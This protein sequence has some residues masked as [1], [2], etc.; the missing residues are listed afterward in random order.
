[1]NKRRWPIMLASLL[2]AFLIAT[3]P[4]FSVENNF[5]NPP[6]KVNINSTDNSFKSLYGAVCLGIF[7]Y[8][9][10]AV[11]KLTK[12]EIVRQYPDILFNS[13]IRFDL[14]NLDLGKKGWTRYY[15]FSVGNKDFIMRIFL[16]S[17]RAFQAPVAALFEGNIEQP[18]VTFQVLPC[19]NEILADCKIK[20]TRIYP[21]RQ[22]DSSP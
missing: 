1:M 9:L 10:D 22:V 16:T 2:L 5:L 20:P 18:A 21:S 14:A 6:L 12:E 15:P 4:L 17:E 13:E 3:P 19:L 11:K 8:E 7:F